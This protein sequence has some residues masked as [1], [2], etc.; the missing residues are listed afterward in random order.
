MKPGE[1]IVEFDPSRIRPKGDHVL[2]VRF[3]TQEMV[4]RFYRPEYGGAKMPSQE[5]VVVRVGDRV[6]P[7]VRGIKPGDH[8]WLSV[9]IRWCDAQPG[10]HFKWKGETYALLPG[11]YIEAVELDDHKKEKS[12]VRKRRG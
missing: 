10:F 8:V 6:H 7:E 11:E 4:G 3:K 1:P 12:N 5:A 2:V 9:S